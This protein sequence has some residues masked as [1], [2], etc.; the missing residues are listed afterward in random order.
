MKLILKTLQNSEV[1]TED[2]NMSEIFGCVE[3]WEKDLSMLQ[4]DASVISETK[5]SSSASESFLSATSFVS[6]PRSRL[7]K[8]C[9]ELATLKP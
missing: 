9:A 3:E 7:R 8:F 6:T 4:D 5:L 1:P 2:Q